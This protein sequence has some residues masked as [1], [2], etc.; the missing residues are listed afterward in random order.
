MYINWV[1]KDPHMYRLV[2]SLEDNMG[3]AFG[4]LSR[5]KALIKSTLKDEEIK[6]KETLERGLGLLDQSINKLH[7]SEALPGNVAFKLY[8]TYG[9]PIVPNSR[10]FKRKK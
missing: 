6:F 9:F 2:N 10:Y 4:E 8:D 3:D 7:T 5:A 1:L